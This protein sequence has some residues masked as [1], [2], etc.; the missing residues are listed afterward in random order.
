MIWIKLIESG[1]QGSVI[2][3]ISVLNVRA[4][5]NRL[6]FISHPQFDVKAIS[7]LDSVTFK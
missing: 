7:I 1:A 5:N 2:V 3:H 6:M 4:Q